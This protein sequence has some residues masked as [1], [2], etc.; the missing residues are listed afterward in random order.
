M[1]IFLLKVTI[2]GWRLGG[3]TIL[4]NTHIV[5]PTYWTNN[6]TSSELLFFADISTRLRSQI[7]Q[8]CLHRIQNVRQ[9]HLWSFR[10][11][12]RSFPVS[13]FSEENVLQS[14]TEI[15]NHACLSILFGR[16]L[17]TESLF[18]K[19]PAKFC[20]LIQDHFRII[21]TRKSRYK[22]CLKSSEFVSLHPVASDW[23]LT[24]LIHPIQL[25]ERWIQKLK[26][27]WD[28][29]LHIGF[30]WPFTNLFGIGKPS[31]LASSSFPLHSALLTKPLCFWS[32]TWKICTAT[33]THVGPETLHKL[34]SLV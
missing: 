14:S 34:R 4:G 21:S 5:L 29:C 1:I 23:T 27:T 20:H 19:M 7:V 9:F 16:F 10:E 28:R 3:T 12:F 11:T 2:L 30:Y 17:E 13:E 25:L 32:R 22:I 24:L 8:R 33:A 15:Y 6:F 31:I 26:S 18:T